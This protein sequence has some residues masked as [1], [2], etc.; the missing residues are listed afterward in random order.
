MNVL[1]LYR[2]RDRV[3]QGGTYDAV[4]IVACSNIELNG[5]AVAG[6]PLASASSQAVRIVDSADVRVIDSK[7]LGK[8]ATNGVPFHALQPDAT[9]NVIG[10]PA[11]K[12]VNVERTSGFVLRNSRITGFAGGVSFSDAEVTLEGND[13]YGLRTTPIRGV[14]RS[15]SRF[16]RNRT[17]GNTPWR[18]GN[19]RKDGGSDGDHGAGLH[20]FVRL[21]GT[22]IA[23]LVIADNSFD[24]AGMLGIEI[25]DNGF[26]IGFPGIVVSRNTITGHHGGGIT[27]E[28]TSGT[29][30]GNIMRWDGIGR[31]WN[32]APRITPTAGSHDL[33][34]SGNTSN[35]KRPLVDL[36]SKSLTAAGRATIVVRP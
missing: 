29:V 19:D 3:I 30:S 24:V 15:G 31:E 14:P 18:F 13:I 12:G 27:L 7:V 6:P 26:K 1:T 5:I 21:G 23:D 11:G 25:D 8:P 16:I 20:L 28:F 36:T 32:D 2:V 17:W 33:L 22:P 35:Y 10:L 34:L 9:G 4:V